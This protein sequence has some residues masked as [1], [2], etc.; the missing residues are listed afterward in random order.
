MQYVCIHPSKMMN[1]GASLD[2]QPCSERH[3]LAQK[4]ALP[5]VHELLARVLQRS[6]L[7]DPAVRYEAALSHAIDRKA[8][9]LRSA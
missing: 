1:P 7:L 5:L 3:V 8:S 2:P 9:D 6:L 4:A